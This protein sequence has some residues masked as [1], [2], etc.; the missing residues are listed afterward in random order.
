MVCDHI[1]RD[2]IVHSHKEYFRRG[3]GGA[4]LK[5]EITLSGNSELIL[6]T[7]KCYQKAPPSQTLEEYISGLTSA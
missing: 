1:I 5:K 6:T 2:H 4:L 3:G 7:Q